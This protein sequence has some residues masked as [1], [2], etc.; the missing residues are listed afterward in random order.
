MTNPTNFRSSRSAMTDHPYDH[1]QILRGVACLMV[2]LNHVAGLLSGGLEGPATWYG[3]LLVPLG[4]PW[5]WLFLIL[6]GFLL[7]KQFVD[8]RTRLTSSGILNFYKRRCR[9][10]L[11]MLWFAPLLLGI[12]YSCNIWSP[13]LPAF[14]PL[15]ETK[16]ALA[17]P[18]VPY[19]EAGNPVSTANSPVWS[20][21]LEVHYFVILP[22]LLLLTGMSS[23]AILLLVGGWAMAIAGLAVHV[24]LYGSPAIFPMIYQQHFYNGGFMLAGC[25]IALLKIRPYP[26]S[27]WWPVSAVFALIVAT[28]YL[29]NYDL[30]IALAVLPLVAA[31]AF[32]FLVI[33]SISDRQAAVP[34]SLR[35]L[36]LARGPLR[37]LELAGMMSYSIYL[38]HKPLSYIAIAQLRIAG[39]AETLLSLLVKTLATGALIAPV[40]VLSFVFVEHKFRHRGL[41]KPASMTKV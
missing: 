8:G 3:P 30:N 31:P 5:V 7:T 35:A 29:A 1:F 36:R 25:A 18:W 23:K 19:L 14:S 28:Q 41:S 2:F 34:T 27:W 10:L 13:L 11:P 26:V 17:L 40:I 39:D 9:R 4:F 12:L 15:Q 32:A 38:L 24:V 6:S 20:A 21:V 33:Q 16:V 37:W 22:L